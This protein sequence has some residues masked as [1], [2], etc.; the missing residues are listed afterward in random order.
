[1]VLRER[2]YTVSEFEAFIALEE[3]AER[4]FELIDGEIVEKVPTEEHSLIVGNFYLALRTFVDVRDLGR[5]AF[6]VRR[7]VDDDDHN[8]RLPD[9]QFT[10][11][12][13]LLPIVKKGA[14][15]QMPDLAIEVKSPDDTF[16]KLRQK[17]IYYLNNGARLVWLVFPDQRQIEI[18]TSDSAVKTLGIDDILDGGTVLPEFSIP[19]KAIFRGL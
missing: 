2:L 5:V 6:E 18:H 4:V 17:A 15:P 12:E 14:V 9:C 10:R 3:N 11:K 7:K 1:M 13:R 19:V 8:A 16:I